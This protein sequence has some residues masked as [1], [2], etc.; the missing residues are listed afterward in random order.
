MGSVSSEECFDQIS[1]RFESYSLSADVSESESS[2][3]FSCRR[4]D[5]EV[6]MMKERFS[7][8]LLGEDMSGGGNGVFTALAV[9]NAITNLSASVFG[10]LWKLQPLSPQRK[11]WRREMD[12]ILCVTDSIVELKPSLQEF[13][14]GGSFEVMVARARISL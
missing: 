2:S 4:F 12:W 13:P 1:E 3:G 6:E 10:E 11:L 8:L 14:C 9:S 7:K 5:Q